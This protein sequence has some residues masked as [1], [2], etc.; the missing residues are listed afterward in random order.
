MYLI[1]NTQNY[2]KLNFKN[3]KN[4]WKSIFVNQFV[5]RTS[6]RLRQACTSAAL[7]ISKSWRRH[8]YSTSFLII[9]HLAAFASIF[10][11]ESSIA[12]LLYCLIHIMWPL[13]K[14]W[15]PLQVTSRWPGDS[16]NAILKLDSVHVNPTDTITQWVLS[17][18]FWSVV[19]TRNIISSINFN[20]TQYHF[21]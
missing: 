2:M 9:V 12:S 4:D 15:V 3:R 5:N 11:W 1:E 19:C 21:D 14:T 13:S 16:D 10:I 6:W 20:I 7:N 8:D 18:V 17:W